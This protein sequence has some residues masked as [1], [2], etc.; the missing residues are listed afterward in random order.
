MPG[1]IPFKPKMVPLNTQK[2]Y[3]HNVLTGDT[4]LPFVNYYGDTVPSGVALQLSGKAIPTADIAKPKRVP[5]S[6]KHTLVRKNAYPNRVIVPESVRGIPLSDRD[7]RKVTFTLSPKKDTSQFVLSSTADT[8]YTGTPIPATGKVIELGYPAATSAKEMRF[9][10]NAI[11]NMQYLD[12]DQGLSSS[13]ILAILEDSKGNLWIGTAG[14]GLVRYDGNTLLTFTKKQGLPSNTIRAIHEDSTGNLWFTTGS[15]GLCKYNGRE[16]TIYSEKEGLVHN[17]ASALLED[18]SGNLWIGTYGGLTRFDGKSFVHFTTKQGLPDDYIRSLAEDNQGNLW[19]GTWNGAARFDGHTFTQFTVED[20]LPNPVIFV[21]KPDSEGNVW[22]GTYGGGVA[23]YTGDSLKYY[24]TKEGLTANAVKAI[25]E[26]RY[27]NLWFGTNGGG[28]CKLNGS[29]IERYTE[30][31]GLPN[32]FVR[33]ILEDERGNLW[34]GT[35]GGGLVRYIPGSFQHF[36]EKEGLSN[37]LVSSVLEDSS[38]NLWMGT[39]DR[40]VNKFDGETFTHYTVANGLSFDY[41]KSITQDRSGHLWFSTFG[42]GTNRFDGKSFTHFTEN[43]GISD[44]RVSTVYQDSKG[45]YW[46]ATDGGGLTLYDG[47]Q[48]RHFTEKEGFL[49]DYVSS[50]F[51]DHDGN[52]WFGTYGQGVAKYNGTS[53]I[54]YTE[55][56]GLADNH[57]RSVSQDREGS[58]WFSTY[59]GGITRFNGTHFTHYTQGAGLTNNV[60]KSVTEDRQ[61][62][63]WITTELGINLLITDEEGAFYGSGLMNYTGNDGLKGLDFMGNSA[64]LDSKNRLW[65]GNGKCLSMLDLNV[66]SVPEKATPVQLR[67]IEINNLSTDFRN[68]PD[69]LLQQLEFEGVAPFDNFPLN[70]TL[71]HNYNHLSFKFSGIDPM[72]PH[73]ITYSYIMD[74]LDETWSTPSPIRQADYR[75]IPAGD[76]VFKVRALGKSGLWGEPFEYPFTIRPPWYETEAYYIGQTALFSIL[77]ILA[78]F[79]NRT[80]N[81]N[82]WVIVLSFIVLITLFEFLLLLAEPYVEDFVSGIPLLKLGINVGLALSLSP[83]ERYLRNKYNI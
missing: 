53:F 38:G 83:I 64:L 69:T 4:I 66:Y 13:Y 29:E 48:F 24:T 71:P 67:S 34:F 8:I 42:G 78:V 19:I 7:L 18:R 15:S 28:V 76:Y 17:S 12:V 75:N 25:H 81:G 41:I 57:V 56:E 45:N 72:T 20:G 2:G 16:L 10:Y 50:A 51:E 49:S 70:P 27:G 58:L 52:L 61:G 32:S 35:D 54:Y 74:G 9:K 3:T 59:G 22:F 62:R 26:D 30:E 46:F 43:T 39:L 31:N 73:D 77:V 47:V 60:V 82:E 14:G 65:L 68:I 44:N 37:N 63:Y 5:L 40:G 36:T 21:V 33:S 6:P 80:H 1:E 11:N 23:K 79:L 55:K